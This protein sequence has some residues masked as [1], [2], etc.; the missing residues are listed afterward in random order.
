VRY[1]GEAQVGTYLLEA[2]NA[3]LKRMVG[4]REVAIGTLKE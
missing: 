4:E 2:E 3:K 1:K